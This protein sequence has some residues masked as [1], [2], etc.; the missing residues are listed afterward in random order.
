MNYYLEYYYNIKIKEKLEY[1]STNLFFYQSY[2][3]CFT[4]QDKGKINYDF[5]INCSKE[6]R[7]KGFNCHEIV[8]NRFNSAVSM[9][10]KHP[11]ILLKIFNNNPSEIVDFYDLIRDNSLFIVN[12]SYVKN[13]N[14][15]WG[16]LWQKKWLYYRV[17]PS[18]LNCNQC[19][20]PQIMVG[21]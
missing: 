2:Y 16:I 13:Y 21:L 1:R 5:V 3:Y 9:I 10:K 20:V 18:R 4:L 15:N 12:N 14:H 11:F 17:N 8:I 7:K 6:L 19:S